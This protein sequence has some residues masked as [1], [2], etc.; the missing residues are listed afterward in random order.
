MRAW[1]LALALALLACKSDGP[2]ATFTLAT[3]ESATHYGLTLT[4]GGA[5]HSISRSGEKVFVEVQLERD[6]KESSQRLSSDHW[7]EDQE[8]FGVHWRVDK[9]DGFSPKQATFTVLRP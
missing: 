6:G 9:A 4:Y 2:Q 7:H 3:H 8:S 1:L 5:G